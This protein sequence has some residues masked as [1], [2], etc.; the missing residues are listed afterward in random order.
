M[1]EQQ[2][3]AQPAAEL[4]EILRGMAD[5]A[6]FHRDQLKADQERA[7]IATALRVLDQ[8]V[9]GLGKMVQ[10]HERELSRLAALVLAHQEIIKRATGQPR[11]SGEVN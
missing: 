5:A 7:E 4:P 2:I 9:A 8:A 10:A 11:T 1:N 6:A 3:D